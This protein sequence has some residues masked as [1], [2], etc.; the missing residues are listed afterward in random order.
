MTSQP[1]EKP[2]TAKVVSLKK[3]R[4]TR[5]GFLLGSL[6][7][8]TFAGAAGIGTAGYAYAEARGGLLVTPYRIVSPRWT[9]GQRLSIT[10]IADL[11]AGGPNMRVEK[12]RSIV[13]TANGLRS[14]I[15]VLLGDYVATHRFVDPVVAHPVW[16]AELKR[17]RA[18][19]GVWA[20]LGNHDWWHG[21]DS[22]RKA[23]TD[24]D[25]PVL[26]NQVVPLGEEGNRFWLA[27]LGDQIAHR[28][29]HNRFRGEDDLPGTLARVRTDDPILLLAHEPDIFPR[30]PDNVALT[31]AGHTH[32]GQIRVPF[33]WPGYVP[34]AY[35]A[36]Y[37]YGHIIEDHRHMV[38]SGG[39]GT[40]IVPLRLGVPPEIVHVEVRGPSLIGGSADSR[41]A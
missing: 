19:F 12:I 34:S 29:G 2:Q 35:G 8:A 17:L 27:G 40:S 6:G 41:T 14:D 33:I 20:I 28:I 11:H 39:L 13:D 24:V 7:I 37:A 31:L 16:A 32:G 10:V 26:E 5:R 38:V 25:I 1:L 23:L 4:M 3:R 22:V 9:S 36:R 18:P 30:V 21:V 15:I